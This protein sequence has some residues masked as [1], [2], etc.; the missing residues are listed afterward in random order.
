MYNVLIRPIVRRLNI[1]T[2]SSFVKSYFKLI[3]LLP[4]AHFINRLIHGNKPMGLQK[5]VFGLQFYNPVGLGAGLDTK[6]DIYYELENLGVSFMEI[7]PM[8]ASVAKHAISQIQ[9]HPQNDILMACIS[10][11]FLLAFS[12]AYDFCDAFVLDIGNHSVEEAVEPVIDYRLSSDSYKPVIV[13]LPENLDS[14]TLSS[15]LDYC[16]ITGIDG[17]ETRSLS[18]TSIV[19]DICLGRYPIIANCHIKTPQEAFEALEAGA[20]LVE[21]RSGIVTE[22]PRLVSKILKYLSSFPKYVT[23]D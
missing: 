19:N 6:G 8:N 2:A 7:G 5:E 9:K 12:L 4:G 18:Q 3:S 13:K 22:G 23:N 15:I 10:D 16:R 14:D 17:I 21:I 1:E 11:D 20:T